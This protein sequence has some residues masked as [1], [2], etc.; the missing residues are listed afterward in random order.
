[1]QSWAGRAPPSQAVQPNSKQGPPVGLCLLV[2]DAR[3][4]DLE[5]C[6]YMMCG[7]VGFEGRLGVEEVMYRSSSSHCMPSAAAIS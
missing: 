4:D 1:M 6:C 3:R 7:C 5:H 2:D